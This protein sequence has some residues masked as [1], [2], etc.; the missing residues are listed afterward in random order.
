MFN[1]DYVKIFV[2]DAKLTPDEARAL[3]KKAEEAGAT[4]VSVF[5]DATVVVSKTKLWNR[6]KKYLPPR[7]FVSKPHGCRFASDAHS[8]G[9]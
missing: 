1:P 4:I 6:L 2:I 5:E 7:G 3:A 9:K 8:A